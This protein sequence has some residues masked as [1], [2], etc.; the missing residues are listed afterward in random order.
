MQIDNLS[1]LKRDVDLERVQKEGELADD[2][3]RKSIS[4]KNLSTNV[5]HTKMTALS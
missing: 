5:N 3:V 1:A 2:K 4:R